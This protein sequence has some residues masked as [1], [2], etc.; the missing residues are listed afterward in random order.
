[1]HIGGHFIKKVVVHPQLKGAGHLI[2]PQICI[3]KDL[4]LVSFWRCGTT[5]SSIV[6]KIKFVMYVLKMYPPNI[7][8]PH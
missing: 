8:W 3:W 4:G 5:L 1:M 2:R 6:Y 7:A